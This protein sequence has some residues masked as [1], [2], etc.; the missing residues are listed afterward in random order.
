MAKLWN[1]WLKKIKSRLK[2]IKSRL[3]KMESQLA[4]P[5]NHGSKNSVA[6]C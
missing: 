4:N 2:K 1:S 3:K 6:A 5:Q